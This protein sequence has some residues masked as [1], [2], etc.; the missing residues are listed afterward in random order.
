MTYSLVF[1]PALY[2]NWL[3]S[4]SILKSRRSSVF[5]WFLQTKC[6][7]RDSIFRLWMKQQ[8][9]SGRLVYFGTLPIRWNP[10]SHLFQPPP[11]KKKIYFWQPTIRKRNAGSAIILAIFFLSQRLPHFKAAPAVRHLFQPF[12]SQTL[13]LRC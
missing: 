4:Y 12:I 5:L 1:V 3:S 11:P 9:C 13:G 10:L 7:H 2:D 8:T 6:P